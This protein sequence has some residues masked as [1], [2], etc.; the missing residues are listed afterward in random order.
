MIIPLINYLRIA[1]VVGIVLLL[2]VDNWWAYNKGKDSVIRNVVAGISTTAKQQEKKAVEDV[3]QASA[4]TQ[5]IA[6]LQSERDNLKKDLAFAVDQ[7]AT[8]P[9]TVT[10]TRTVYVKPNPPVPSECR[11]NDHQLWLLKQAYGV[12]DAPK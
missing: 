10:K 7:L 5:T 1:G 4:D 11:I 6:Q 2:G 9:T 8:K 12:K 3:K